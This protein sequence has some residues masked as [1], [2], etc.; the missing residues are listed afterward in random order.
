MRLL[1]PASSTHQTT[2]DDNV[3]FLLFVSALHDTWHIELRVMP[4]M[5]SS[6]D[7]CNLSTQARGSAEESATAKLWTCFMLSFP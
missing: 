3:A 2:G 6:P 4:M 5:A 7:E 1:V